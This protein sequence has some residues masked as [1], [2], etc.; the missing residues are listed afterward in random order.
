MKRIFTAALLGISSIAF[1]ATL[2]PIQLLN[3]AGSTAGQAPVS[4]GPTTPPTWGNITASGLVAQAANTVV[5]NVTGS[6]AAP[7]AF[8]MPSCS[9][10][11]NALRYTTST[12]FTC[13][14]G[15]AL[16][17]SGLNQFA[18]TTS[19]Q[20]LGV[21]SD[22]TGSGSLV[23]GSG[24]TINQPK[25]VG[26]TTNTAAAAGNVGEYPTP[27]VGT[28]VALSSATPAN[29]TSISLT[30]GDWDVY[31]SIMFTGNATTST[32]VRMAGINTVSATLP[33][34]PDLGEFYFGSSS[35][36]ESISVAIPQTR[37]LLASTTTVYL[38]AQATFTTSNETATCKLQARRRQ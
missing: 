27:G 26:V 3:P 1:A 31:G 34:A 22:E 29:C 6:S 21:I 2:Y 10:S 14:S 32:S 37:Q 8:A 23:F 25:I 13:A 9:G 36:N 11:N 33:A 30:A 24:P 4:T 15:V 19:A 5:A 12:G 17:A 7:D 16:T 28:A 38:V 18:A 20:L 35:I